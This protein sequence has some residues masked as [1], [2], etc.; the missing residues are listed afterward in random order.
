M[1]EPCW[2]GRPQGAFPCG[3]ALSSHQGQSPQALTAT[4]SSLLA[5][6]TCTLLPSAPRAQPGPGAPHKSWWDL[7]N[8][9]RL[10][11]TL[12]KSP[13]QSLHQDSHT[14]PPNTPVCS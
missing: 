2:A 1:T 6:A 5:R 11:S 8:E 9:G 10:R 4:I 7:L 12:V 14:K 3:L 13:T